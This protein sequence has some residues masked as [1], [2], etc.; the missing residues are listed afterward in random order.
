MIRKG[1]LNVL[2]CVHNQHSTIVMIFS[3]S[4]LHQNRIICLH[5]SSLV[6]YQQKYQYAFVSIFF[7]SLK[8]EMIMKSYT[9]TYITIINLS[10]TYVIMNLRFIF[11]TFSIYLLKWFM[12]SVSGTEQTSRTL[13][14]NLI[15]FSIKN[16]E[17]L[18]NLCTSASDHIILVTH[19]DTMCC[20]SNN[21]IKKITKR[22]VELQ[23]ISIFGCSIMHLIY[24]YEFLGYPIMRWL[25]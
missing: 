10:N 21:K 24:F 11:M 13:W 15:P 18:H 20:Y 17:K 7:H 25:E 1:K 2:T 9:F 6:F 23:T 19:L 3:S 4:S 22:I 12:R 14:F 5:I 8:G 16:N